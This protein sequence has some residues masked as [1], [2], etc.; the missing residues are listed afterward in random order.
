VLESLTNAIFR[1]VT[2]VTAREQL[3][4]ENTK[5]VTGATVMASG[6]TVQK[7]IRER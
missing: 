2:S 4:G 5:L 3:A 6:T 1:F 7:K